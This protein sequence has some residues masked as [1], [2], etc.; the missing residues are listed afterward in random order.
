[1]IYS[2]MKKQHNCKHFVNYDLLEIVYIQ[3]C[4]NKLKAS[5]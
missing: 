1:M 4:K 5:V 2:A 3:Y